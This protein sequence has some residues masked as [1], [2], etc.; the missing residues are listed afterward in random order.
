[1]TRKIR[2]MKKWQKA[3]MITGIAI[4]LVGILIWCVK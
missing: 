1:M 2:C 4:F 3:V